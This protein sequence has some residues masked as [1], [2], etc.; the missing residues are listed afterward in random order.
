M[1]HKKFGGHTNS[2]GRQ[3]INNKILLKNDINS[4]QLILKS[5]SD[6]SF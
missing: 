3:I 4:I 2:C 1:N 5:L 6:D